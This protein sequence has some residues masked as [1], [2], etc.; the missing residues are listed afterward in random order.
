MRS[1]TCKAWLCRKLTLRNSPKSM[2]PDI[3]SS[4]SE[5]IWNN[6][7][8]VGFWPIASNTCLSSHTSMVP[9][10]SLSN[11]KKASRHPSISSCVNGI[12]RQSVEAFG[13]LV[14]VKLMDQFGCNV[15]D[16]R[17]LSHHP[18]K[19]MAPTHRCIPL[20][21]HQSHRAFKRSVRINRCIFCIVE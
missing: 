21:C 16:L 17:T 7:S 6:S 19:L 13:R 3:L 5:I 10:R 14:V 15:K 20:F 18:L 11:A 9:L 8:S 2:E 12:I 4:T 1:Y